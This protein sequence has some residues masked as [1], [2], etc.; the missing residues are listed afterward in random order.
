MSVDGTFL[1]SQ[2]K[3]TLLIAVANDGGDKLV[4]LA[5]ALV[6]AE[7][8]DNWEWFLSLVRTKVIGPE[9]EVCII[10][11]RHPGILN[12][13]EIDIPGHPRVHHRWCM[14]HFVSNFY[15]HVETRNCLTFFMIVVSHSPLDILRNCGTKCMP[16]QTMVAKIS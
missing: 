10:S 1:T 11:D 4:P 15:E 3:G 14:R 16:K 12:A 7:N 9:R 8:S 2:F 5:F 6:L 13:V